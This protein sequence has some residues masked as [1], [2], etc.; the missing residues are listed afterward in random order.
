MVAATIF[1]DASDVVGLAVGIE[2]LAAGYAQAGLPT[3]CRMV[4]AGVDDLRIAGAHVRADGA[5][6]LEYDHLAPGPRQGARDRETHP[7]DQSTVRSSARRTSS[8]S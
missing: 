4:E 2:G 5:L 3:S 7:D 8:R 6:R 1:A